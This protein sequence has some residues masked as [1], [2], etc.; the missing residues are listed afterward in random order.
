MESYRSPALARWEPAVQAV[1]DAAIAEIDGPIAPAPPSSALAAARAERPLEEAAPFTTRL[2]KVLDDY[3]LDAIAGFVL[4]GVGDV[5]TGVGSL[6]VLA[7]ALREGVPTV[8]LFRMVLNILVDVVVGSIPFAG[9]LFDVFWRSNRRNLDLVE[10]YRGGKEK[11]SVGDYLL[12]LFGV[13]FA[14]LTIVMPAL[15]FSGLIG[16]FASAF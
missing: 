10:R 11:P 6:A 7:T 2:V 15:W 16:A 12:A 14:L 1:V 3:G 9:D 4:P 8:I 13:L 5:A